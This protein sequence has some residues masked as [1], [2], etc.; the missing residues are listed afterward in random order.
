MIGSKHILL[1]AIILTAC[2]DPDPEIVQASAIDHG[3]ALFNDP[4]IAGTSVNSYACGTCHQA[5]ASADDRI[6]VGAP[7]AGAIERPSFWGGA[8]LELLDA[9]NECLTIFMFKSEPWN[10]EEVDA[11]AMFAYLESLPSGPADVAAAPFTVVKAIEPLTGGDASNGA[12]VYQRACAQCHGAAHTAA[13][14]PVPNATLLPEDAN[15]GHPAPEYAAEDRAF[16]F[17]EKARHGAF[18]F[19]DGTMPPFSAENL[20]DEEL[21]DIVA[22]LGPYD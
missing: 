3:K 9:I 7:L 11:R 1:G 5:V 19:Y 20:S 16:I 8:R 14:R 13:N 18:L 15:A 21:A 2:G 22:F 4:S 12:A 10:G 17:V 6:F